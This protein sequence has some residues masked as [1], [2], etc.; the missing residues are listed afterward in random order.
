MKLFGPADLDFNVYG[1]DFVA[2]KEIS[3][4]SPYAGV[5]GYWA[6]G[7]ETTDNSLRHLAAPDEAA[8]RV[9]EA[10][11]LSEADARGEV[12]VVGGDVERR[13]LK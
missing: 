4:F 1:L 7:Q 10:A 3:R 12:D 11:R 6:R 5:S 2:S 8:L 9:A 13:P